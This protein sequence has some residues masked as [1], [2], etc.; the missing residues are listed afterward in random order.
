VAE[1]RY[2]SA[3]AFRQAMEARLQD[4]AREGGLVLQRIRRQVSFDRLLARMFASPEEAGWVLKGGY[5][6][7]LRFQSARST[8][9]V[10]LTMRS[11][12]VVAVTPET[13]RDALRKHLQQAA[14]LRLPDFFEFL[15][16]RATLDLEGAPDG[17]FR[18]PVEA[19]MDGRTFT[20]FHVD[21]GIGDDISEPAD[22]LEGGDWLAFAG[23]PRPRFLAVSR[24]RQWAEKFHAYTRPRKD[25]L[26][27]RA[28][29]LM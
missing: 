26:N 6:L 15:I 21:I 10:D 20:R 7:E 2:A 3:R 29:D 11:G 18:F 8:K 14:S 23:L 28:K 25:R 19:L 5:A 22:V 16:R 24:E 12:V 4:R 13:Q 27:S 17:G 1:P 9:D